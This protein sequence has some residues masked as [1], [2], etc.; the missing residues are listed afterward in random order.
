MHRSAEENLQVTT[1]AAD[2]LPALL[3]FE[4]D[5]DFRNGAG[6]KAQK[7]F[8]DLRRNQLGRLGGVEDKTYKG[9]ARRILD[10]FKGKYGR[11]R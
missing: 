4:K 10:F 1:S 5:V 9:M 11:Y 3:L 7:E 2:N 8:P 6:V